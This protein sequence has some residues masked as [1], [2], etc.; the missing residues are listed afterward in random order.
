MS[1]M[2]GKKAWDKSKGATL[3]LRIP[4]GRFALPDETAV[5]AAF[6]TSARADVV[7]GADL[8]VD[9]GYAIN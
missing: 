8:L 9:G 3:K 6:L 2:V 5:A 4:V 7:A 1:Q